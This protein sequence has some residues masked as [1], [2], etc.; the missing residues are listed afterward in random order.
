MRIAITEA[1]ADLARRKGGALALD[2]IAPL[3]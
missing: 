2:L 3:G 1:A